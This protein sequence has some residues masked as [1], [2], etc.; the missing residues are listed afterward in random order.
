MSPTLDIVIA[1][2]G[3]GGLTAALAL[4]A[5]GHRV[6]IYEA[7]R[8]IKP[9]G[10]G[11]NVLPHAVSVLS[12]LGLA[13]TLEAAGVRT[14]EVVFANRFGQA[15]FSDPRGLEGGYAYPQYSI[16]RGKLQMML[17]DTTRKQLGADAIQTNA[18][19]T[20]FQRTRG[21]VVAA[22]TS[23][24][25]SVEIDCDLLIAA[26]GIHSAAR[27]K[28]YPDE[29]APKWNG[30]TMWR[31]TTIAKPFLSGRSMLQAGHSRAKFVCYPIEHFA[32]GSALINWIADIRIGES[33]APPARE[34]WNKPG[35]VE[36][37]MPTFGD[38]QFDYLD[39]PRLIREASAIYEFPMVD[40]DPLPRWSFDRVTL[41]G[42]AA[43]P[44]Y[45]IGSNG[46]TQAI[47]DARALAD[48]FSNNDKPEIA[49]AAYESARRP[50]ASEI[51]ALNRKAG[52]DAV[53]DLV[54]ENAPNGFT[55]IEDAIDPA[56]IAATIR[57]YK[58]AAGHQLN[59]ATRQSTTQLV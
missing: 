43:H 26:D 52:L 47:L 24:D 49:L 11:I 40:R 56:I 41:L 14:K 22:F 25:V 55:R 44:M 17:L 29:G 31:G 58:Q 36:D 35:R 1:G 9:L 7:V 2:A 3:I 42:D 20:D 4:H 59:Q 45:P 19:L 30:V 12:S 27:R 13:N 28:F 51:V 15:I 53:L 5:G 46:A 33:G 39:V 16:H 54:H 38:W 57:N 48:A 32:D 18:R 10:V 6:R 34:D 37:L 21:Q 8:E 50:M 23:N